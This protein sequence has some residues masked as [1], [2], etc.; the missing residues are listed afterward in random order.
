MRFIALIFVILV[1]GL[2]VGFSVINSQSKVDVN[3]FGQKYPTVPVVVV[4]FYSFLGGMIFVLVFAVAN[5]IVLRRRLSRERKINENL[6]KELEALRNYPI[7]EETE[8]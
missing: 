4:I 3:L 7:S 1:V 8:K 5:E 2:L 6:K